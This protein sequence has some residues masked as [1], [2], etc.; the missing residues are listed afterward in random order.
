MKEN[1]LPDIEE[2]LGEKNCE[3][4]FP[5][6]FIDNG[7]TREY[8]WKRYLKACRQDAEDS[9][10]CLT[11]CSNCGACSPEHRKKMAEYRR[12]KKKDI[13]IKLDG[14]PG[15]CAALREE[16]MPRFYAVLDF[17]V[18]ELHSVVKGVYWESELSRAL[19]YAGISYDRSTL[20]ALRPFRDPYDW[21]IGMNSI[22]AAFMEKLPDGELIE[23]I[24]EHTVHMQVFGIR[25]MEGP[26]RAAAMSYQIPCPEGTDEIKLQKM[27]DNIME[28][29]TWEYA[30]EYFSDGRFWQ[31][32]LDLRAG[33]MELFLKKHKICMKLDPFTPPYHIYQ[34]LLGI[35][36]EIAGK[37]RAERTEVMF[38][39]LDGLHSQKV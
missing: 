33:I 12:I 9:P 27:I 18:D 10:R 16:Q 35:P 38:E 36:W 21:A 4:V 28:G 39:P 32:E 17:T 5:W 13:G 1:K 2:W 29:D 30:A 3:T 11:K 23:R 8:L 26:V 15:T 31:K 22:T 6:D 37:Y 14:F 20:K 25:W 19:N 24:N 34:A 7:V